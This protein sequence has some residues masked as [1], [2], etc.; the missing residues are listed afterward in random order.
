MRYYTSKVSFNYRDNIYLDD[1]NE[2]ID[3][4][5]YLMI[6]RRQNS[7]VCNIDNYIN[8]LYLRISIGKICMI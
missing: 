3:K 1:Q 2:E 6:N 4:I 5:L 7:M 8:Y